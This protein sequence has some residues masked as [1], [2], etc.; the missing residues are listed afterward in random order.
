M[1]KV[2][3]TK[4]QKG[5]EGTH[6]A[7]RLGVDSGLEQ[8]VVSALFGHRIPGLG[9]HIVLVDPWVLPQLLNRRPA[10]EKIIVNSTLNST[11]DDF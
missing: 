6:Q 1:H 10:Q 7:E 4:P 9:N 5:G 8:V 2:H 3:T 11:G